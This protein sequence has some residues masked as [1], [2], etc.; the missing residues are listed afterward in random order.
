M[1]V[2]PVDCSLTGYMRVSVDGNHR[3]FEASVIQSV[4]PH[5]AYPEG[6]NMFQARAG[7]PPYVRSGNHTT[8]K[9]GKRTLFHVPLVT[10]LCGTGTS[11]LPTVVVLLGW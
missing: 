9:N 8:P 7:T 6:A 2:P 4:S 10:D 11:S 5:R 3:P 1:V